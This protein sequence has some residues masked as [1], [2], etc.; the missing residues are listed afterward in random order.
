MKKII[1][2]IAAALMACVC[3]NAQFR[4]D[5]NASTT[6]YSFDNVSIDSK[7]APAV[8]VYTNV[9]DNGRSGLELGLG[10]VQRKGV[11]NSGGDNKE[12]TINDLELPVRFFYNIKLG[13]ILTITPLIGVYADYAIGGKTVL[14]VGSTNLVENSPFDGAQGMKRFDFGGDDEILLTIGQHLTAG[15]GVQYGFLNL[16]KDSTI[17]VKPA[18][19]YLGIGWRF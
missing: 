18:T 13:N 6:V 12:M 7:L 9:L 15:V 11:N 1:V 8:R 5:V 4:V 2:T 16:C 19:A 14:G 17:S 10:Y 3:A